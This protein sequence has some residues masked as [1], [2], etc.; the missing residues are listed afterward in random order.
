MVLPGGTGDHDDFDVEVVGSNDNSDDYKDCNEDNAS[1][2]MLI[3]IW[4]LIMILQIIS[5]WFGPI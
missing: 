2:L 3:L 1:I 4:S 5:G